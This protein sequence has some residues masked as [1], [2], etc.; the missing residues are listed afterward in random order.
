MPPSLLPAT[1]PLLVAAVAMARSSDR[2]AKLRTGPV[3]EE[4]G[5]GA[6]DELEA[7][8]RGLRAAR[9]ECPMKVTRRRE[10][11]R[12]FTAREVAT[13][14]ESNRVVMNP[15]RVLAL[16]IQDRAELSTPQARVQLD[17]ILDFR[18]SAP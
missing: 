17:P 10:V 13:L 14:Q 7:P 2:L 1:L 12:P 9:G 11:A 8:G 6:P 5:L 3:E 4:A 16:R 18:D 15:H